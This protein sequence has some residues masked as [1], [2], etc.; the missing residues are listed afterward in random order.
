MTLYGDREVPDEWKEEII[1]PLQRGKGSKKKKK[2][3][4]DTRCSCVRSSP[5]TLAFEPVVEINPL[6]RDTRP[7]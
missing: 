5:A 7:V 6:L 2:V 4:G 1:V 3:R